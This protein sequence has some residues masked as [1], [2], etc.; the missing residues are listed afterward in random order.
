MEYSAKSIQ[1]LEDLEP[2]R[3]RPTQF[4]E[5]TSEAGQCHAQKEVLDNSNDEGSL[6]NGTGLVRTIMFRDEKRKTYQFAIVD[7]GRGIPR[8]SIQ[9][10]FTKLNT[11]GKYDTN[12]YSYSSGSF[13]LGAKVAAGTSHLFMGITKR[14]EG[15]GQIV[16][17]K[18][19][20]RGDA[21]FIDVKLP[22]TGTLVMMEPDDQIFTDIESY[23]DSGFSRYIDLLQ[24]FCIFGNVHQQF[25]IHTKPVPKGFWDM[26]AAAATQF[27][28]TAFTEAQ[29]VFDSFRDQPNPEVFL[30]SYWGIERPFYWQHQ[31]FSADPVHPEMKIMANVRSYYI[32]YGSTSGFMGL[33]NNVPI[34]HGGST[35]TRVVQDVYR[36]LLASYIRD[37]AVREFFLT[38]Y[39]LPLYHAISV[40]RSGAQFTGA[41]KHM[42]NDKDM[43]P[44]YREHLTKLLSTPE[45]Q[46]RITE[47]FNI[48]EDDIQA[49]YQD[50]IKSPMAAKDTGRVF[51]RLNFEG[52]YSGCENKN[53]Q[54]TELILMEGA[55]AGSKVGRNPMTQAIYQLRGKPTNALLDHERMAVSRNKI[56]KDPIYQDI[57]TLLNI[58]PGKGD[59]STM[60][61]GKLI[62]MTDADTHG[63]HIVILLLGN[64][65]AAT[66]ELIEQGK[67]YIAIPPLYSMTL[68]SSD[69]KVFL[70]DGI[71]ATEFQASL[72]YAPSLK[73]WACPDHENSP[74]TRKELIGDQYVDFVERVFEAGEAVEYVAKSLALDVRIVERL[75]YVADA[76]ESGR[77]DL[78]KIQSV[79]HGSDVSYDE[80]LDTLLLTYKSQDIIIPLKGLAQ[81]L[82][83][84]V[85][86]KMEPL[87]WKDITYRV[88]TTATDLFQN[89]PMTP[90]EIHAIYESMSGIFKVNRYKGLGQMP[91]NDRSKICLNT[92][93]RQM[94]HIKNIGDFDQVMRL[95]GKADATHRKN[96]VEA[97]V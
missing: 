40:K 94:Y 3:M 19:I 46:D 26:D 73:V 1:S 51:L 69:K 2:V 97:D 61:F 39:K 96:L 8:E 12:S 29:L 21:K 58:T 23:R 62:L 43:E 70:R 84:W 89:I 79:F 93:N 75:A 9:D 22:E 80:I 86:P 30:K 33:I 28:E 66:P 15:Y 81:Q 42:Y 35:H 47:L 52:N 83:D 7:N 38:K 41:T 65:Y 6:K 87:L 50:M 88:S 32:R 90:I 16:V 57:Y 92:D 54:E 82:R 76:L 20:R 78:A 27:I 36:S 85:V 64:L 49:K 31:V 72:V 25:F 67:V 60:N 14:P 4:I 56:L 17:E 44:V 13:G 24:K 37:P 48:L 74:Y 34:D 10:C 5:D 71:S 45:S 63:Y 91:T 55:S 68:G 18:G 77:V 95:L 53:R 11:S 59:L